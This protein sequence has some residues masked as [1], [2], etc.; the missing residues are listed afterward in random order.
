MD[1]RSLQQ[2]DD[3]TGQVPH[4]QQQFNDYLDR[5]ETLKTRNAAAQ[6][7]LEAI[8]RRLQR[9]INP[10]VRQ[11]I[12]HKLSFVKILDEAYQKGYF[13]IFEREGI[14][15]LL[16]AR[17]FELVYQHGTSEA[18]TLYRRYHQD[19]LEQWLD[20]AE[21]TAQSLLGIFE[22]DDDLE[23]P[24]FRE[25]DYPDPEPKKFIIQTDDLQK[26]LR[27]LYTRLAKHLHPDRDPDEQQRIQKNTLMQ[28]LTA[29]Y[30]SRDWFELLRLH[31][32]HFEEQPPLS[33]SQIQWIN[34]ELHTQ[35]Q[36]LEQEWEQTTQRGDT[37]FIYRRFA[38]DDPEEQDRKFALEK[39]RLQ[40]ELLKL[41]DD[42]EQILDQK[43]AP[44]R[45]R[46]HD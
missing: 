3:S 38:G 15:Q 22:E 18:E 1:E 20:F 13:G 9:E 14:R 10:M 26:I 21:Q 39:M 44:R 6:E 4:W 5:I 32:E 31:Q 41:R 40:N 11:V 29:A 17:T 46:I 43:K 30:Q 27:S 12:E 8:E 42:L 19:P 37:G 28:Q 36:T 25:P 35:C 16:Q 7:R 45:F 23:E 2:Q 24:S 33:P 34:E